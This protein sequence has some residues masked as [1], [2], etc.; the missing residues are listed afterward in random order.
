M[1]QKNKISLRQFYR[2]IDEYILNQ[3]HEQAILYSK[4]LLKKYPKNVMLY[5]LLGKAY[6]DTKQY[7]LAFILFNKILE[8]DPDDFVSHIGSSLISESFGNIEDAYSSMLRAYEIQPSNESLQ[9][10]VLRLIRLKDGFAPE[11]ARL[12]RGALIKMY[13]RSKLTDQA[14]AEAKLGLH[15]SPDRI[16]FKVHLADMLATSGKPEN[17]LE[18]CFRVIKEK[19]YCKPILLLLFRILSNSMDRDQ[20][21]IYKSRL[22]ELDPYFSF[23]KPDTNS[24][25]D[26]PDV[27]IMVNAGDLPADEIIDITAFLENEWKSENIKDQN[28]LSDDKPDWEKIVNEAVANNGIGEPI[29]EQDL[30]V[31]NM[32]NSE[33]GISEDVNEVTKTKRE[34]LRSKLTGEE[35]SSIKNVS[36]EEEI[37]DWILTYGAIEKKSEMKPEDHQAQNENLEFAPPSESEF[38][39]DGMTDH[40]I[41]INPVVEK[42]GFISTSTDWMRIEENRAPIDNA[43]EIPSL[44]DTQKIKSLKHD[45]KDVEEQLEKALLENDSEFATKCIDFLLN[46]KFDLGNVA[47]KLNN[48]LQANP[49]NIELWLFL[50]RIY[51]KLDMNDNALAALEKAQKMISV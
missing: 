7:D 32:N 15:E 30:D 44:D 35:P 29:D 17:A 20:S 18:I 47:K 13:T 34:K 40:A 33:D 14:I 31:I 12:T 38:K 51:R 39:E 42:D 41:P 26:I 8:I 1:E 16:D 48:Y 23:M 50:V 46:K 10:E 25:N 19:P 9:N 2:N 27:A 49:D 3:S 24:V 37:P 21:I 22:T 28:D 4:F 45:P 11:K 36:A 6:L 43:D 5:Q